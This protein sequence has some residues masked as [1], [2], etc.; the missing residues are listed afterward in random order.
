MNFENRSEAV[1]VQLEAVL[2][3]AGFVEL[4]KRERQKTELW[5]KTRENEELAQTAFDKNRPVIHRELKRAVR[6]TERRMNFLRTAPMTAKVVVCALLVFYLGLTVAVATIKE[7]RVHV[8]NFLIS[9]EDQYTELKL[10]EDPADSYVPSIWDGTYYPSYVP[11]GLKLV[12]IQ[13]MTEFTVRKV[14]YLSDDAAR[15]L[16]FAECMDEEQININTE[17]AKVYWKEIND[18]SCMFVERETEKFTVWSN[19]DRYFYIWTDSACNE[20]DEIVK[21]VKSIK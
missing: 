14:K 19:G 1:E 4:E 6:R 12:E 3:K 16:L 11:T 9:I 21:N 15:W 13:P 8:Y 17:G 10:Q 20:M 2:I 7:V 5:L 18:E